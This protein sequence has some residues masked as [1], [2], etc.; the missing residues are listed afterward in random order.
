VPA[1]L[2]GVLVGLG[3][4]YGLIVLINVLAPLDAGDPGRRA[5]PGLM[6]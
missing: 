5:V 1:S 2:T 3:L 4:G 6:P